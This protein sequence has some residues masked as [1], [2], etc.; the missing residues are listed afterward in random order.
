ML[1]YVKYTI[2]ILKTRHFQ[3]QGVIIYL[4]IITKPYAAYALRKKGTTLTLFM[5]YEKIQ[6]DK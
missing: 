5:N 2:I 1:G 6:P 4:F 3:N